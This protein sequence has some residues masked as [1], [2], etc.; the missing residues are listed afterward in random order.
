M[1][2]SSAKNS[3]CSFISRAKGYNFLT[4][5]ILS[6]LHRWRPCW[7]LQNFLNKTTSTYTMY[8]LLKHFRFRKLYLTFEIVKV[9]NNGKQYMHQA[10]YNAKLRRK[11]LLVIM[12]ER[13]WIVINCQNHGHKE[14]K[15]KPFKFWI[16][17]KVLENEILD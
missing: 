5:R 14:F 16:M 12:D 2:F 9:F 10:Q 15:F 13:F 7:K 8:I 17:H 6:K 11:I 4:L 3:W 1:H